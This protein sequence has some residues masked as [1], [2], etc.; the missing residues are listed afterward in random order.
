V[1]IMTRKASDVSTPRRSPRKR[2][3][4]KNGRGFSPTPPKAKRF[5]AGLLFICFAVSGFYGVILMIGARYLIVCW[6]GIAY[7]SRKFFFV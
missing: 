7:K 5:K 2:G 1:I 3:P 6:S 4:P